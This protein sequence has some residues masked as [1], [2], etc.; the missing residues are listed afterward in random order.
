MTLLKGSIGSPPVHVVLAAI[1]RN[2]MALL[3]RVP[4]GSPPTPYWQLPGGKIKSGETQANAVER[5]V[6]EETGYQCK[7]LR[8]LGARPSQDGAWILNYWVVDL[9]EDSPSGSIQDPAVLEAAW[10]SVH[11][12]PELP[13]HAPWFGPVLEYFTTHSKKET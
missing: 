4:R 8:W 11:K 2:N 10:H 7:A 13:F 5:E 9:L 6:F 12:L 3:V 1:A